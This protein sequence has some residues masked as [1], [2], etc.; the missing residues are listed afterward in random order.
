M[1][2]LI[3][4][5]HSLFP[6]AFLEILVCFHGPLVHQIREMSFE[7]RGLLGTPGDSSFGVFFKVGDAIGNHEVCY[8]EFLIE[9]E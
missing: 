7:L 8:E 2:Q 9:S 1:L 5:L 6:L 3:P 4:L